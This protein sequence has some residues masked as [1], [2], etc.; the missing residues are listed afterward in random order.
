LS[1]PSDRSPALRRLD[2]MDKLMSPI[3]RTSIDV[4]APHIPLS[5]GEREMSVNRRIGGV[6]GAVAVAVIACVGFG[7]AAGPGDPTARRGIGFVKAGDCY[8]NISR[9]DYVSFEGGQALVV[10]RK[11]SSPGLTLEGNQ[12]AEL[13]RWLDG[14]AR[15]DVE[16]LHPPR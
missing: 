11:G 12:G 2:A 6:G 5:L 1:R 16:N 14:P 4:R 3:G 8:I 15:V 13:R 7:L 10:F 9:V